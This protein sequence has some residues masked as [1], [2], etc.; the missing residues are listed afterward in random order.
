MEID[1]V[2]VIAQIVNFLILLWLLKRFLYGPIIQ[3]MEERRERIA[4]EMDEARKREAQAEEEARRHREE[5]RRLEQRRDE[6]MQQAREEAD[7]R[8]REL[9]DQAREEVEEIERRWHENLRDERDAF[10]REIRLRMGREVCTVARHALR[11]LA[12]RELQVQV[13][14][15]FIE[16]VEHLDEQRRRELRDALA[17]AEDGATVI[18]AFELSAGQ[19]KDLSGAIR[20]L[21][22]DRGGLTFRTSADLLCGVEL[23]VA[24]QKIAWSVDSYLAALEESVVEALEREA[25]EEREIEERDAGTGVDDPAQSAELGSP[26]G[27]NE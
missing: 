15:L 17:D 6:L 20:E 21:L 11:D 23:N 2:T 1:A 27:D 25:A 13:V 16:R 18:S 24:G 5:R 4:G 14:S 10:I 26:E 7:R 19:Q 9:I 22:G 3:A 8:R 12:N